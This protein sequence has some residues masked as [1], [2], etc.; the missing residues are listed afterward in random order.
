MVNTSLPISAQQ[1]MDGTTELEGG[2]KSQGKDPSGTDSRRK[3]QPA[4]K[5]AS[6]K[7]RK[8]ANQAAGAK[9]Q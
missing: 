9:Q 2:K 7:G 3:R 5:A 4:L 1:S 8:P 6:K